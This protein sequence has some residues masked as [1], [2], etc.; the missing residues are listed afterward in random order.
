MTAYPRR[1]DPTIRLPRRLE[2]RIL[3]AVLVAVSEEPR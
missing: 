3:A 1:K 2:S